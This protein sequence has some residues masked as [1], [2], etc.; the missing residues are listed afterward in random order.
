M[1][2]ADELTAL[3][4]RRFCRM[5]V[6]LSQMAEQD[7]EAVEATMRLLRDPQVDR[8]RISISKLWRVLNANNVPVCVQVVSAHVRQVCGCP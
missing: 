1:G 8:R 4:E 5:G 7:R 6:A 3:A 2:I